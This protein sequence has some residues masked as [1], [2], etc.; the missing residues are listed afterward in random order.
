[1]CVL[2]V[3][4]P[5]RVLYTWEAGVG[6]GISNNLCHTLKPSTGPT[7]ANSSVAQETKSPCCGLG[8]LAILREEST[9]AWALKLG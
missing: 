5:A 7:S 8:R 9:G 6:S 4:G 3:Q 2:S 1:M